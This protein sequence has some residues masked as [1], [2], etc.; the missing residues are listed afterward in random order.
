MSDL[1][2]CWTKESKTERVEG[3][4]KDTKREKEVEVKEER[5]GRE[6]EEDEGERRWRV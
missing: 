2:T 6:G 5:L 1:S 4:M 3:L